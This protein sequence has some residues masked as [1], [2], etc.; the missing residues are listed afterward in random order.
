MYAFQGLAIVGL[1][2]A[3]WAIL[4][5]ERVRWAWVA[6][7]LLGWAVLATQYLGSALCAG[8][9]LGLL[10][11]RGARADRRWLAGWF[12][13]GLGAVAGALPWALR[14]PWEAVNAAAFGPP[15]AAG[16]LRDALEATQG[17]VRATPWEWFG[18]SGG[19]A[20]W[21]LAWSA[22]LLLL[23]VRGTGLSF[24]LPVGERR[25]AATFLA[26]S[27]WIALS[28]LLLYKLAGF[29]FYPRYYVALVA[30]ATLLMSLVLAS[31]PVWWRAA[32]TGA[33]AVMFLS[34]SLAATTREAREVS[35]SLVRDIRASRRDV[36]MPPVLCSDTSMALAFRAFFPRA[37][38]RM[39]D[40]DERRPLA[41]RALGEDTFL[42]RWPPEWRGRPAWIVLSGWEGPPESR[43]IVT[44]KAL[45]LA[46]SLGATP[47]SSRLCSARAVAGARKWGAIVEVK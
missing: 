15:N 40:G 39:R 30:P 11:A 35:T 24:A 32:A 29:R 17:A 3:A 31:G 10:A 45:G 7:A 38:I 20:V 8:V 1:L 23:L 44:R 46:A 22:A 28:L 4:R 16:V 42:A 47:A 9:W 14:I 12:A 43:D 36:A 41:R 2:G 5:K 6:L 27:F 37:E 33:V 34:H 26:C 18:V 19:G 25:R 21:S 13:S